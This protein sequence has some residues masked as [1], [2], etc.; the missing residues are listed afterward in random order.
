METQ[1]DTTQE[2]KQETNFV[3]NQR[4]TKMLGF[5]AQV[6]LAVSQNLCVLAAVMQ[7]HMK[8]HMKKHMKNI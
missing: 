3:K 4:E 1:K 7:A 2:T 8:I 6:D 5:R